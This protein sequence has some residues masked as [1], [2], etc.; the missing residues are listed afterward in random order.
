[1]PEELVEVLQPQAQAYRTQQVHGQRVVTPSEMALAAVDNVEA[2]GILTERSHQAVWVATADC[3][4]VLIGD[5]ETGRVAAVHAGWRGTAQRILPEAVARFLAA[6][7]SLENLR[8]AIGPAIAGEVY[9]V[10]EPVA[11]Q[12]GASII[13]SERADTPDSILEALRQLPE[14]PLLDDSH[15]KRVRLDVRR[16]NAL[17]LQKLGIS[18][19]QVVIAPYCTYQQPEDFC[20]YRRCKENKVQWSGIISH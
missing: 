2:D 15:P 17:Q 14:P 12:V 3:T 11:A 18:A 1:M 20:S 8:I 7:S 13:P 6:G 19:Q 5:L 10:S 9:Q 16:V 4:P